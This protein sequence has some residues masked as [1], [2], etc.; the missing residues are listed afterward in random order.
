MTQYLCFLRIFTASD[1]NLS[2]AAL[3]SLFDSRRADNIIGSQEVT[4]HGHQGILGPALEPVHS[5]AGDQAWELEGAATELLT[6][7]YTQDIF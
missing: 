2:H 4:R 7:L 1:L 6:N 5:T 3:H